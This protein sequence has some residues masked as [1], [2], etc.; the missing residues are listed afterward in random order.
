MILIKRIYQPASHPSNHKPWNANFHVKKIFVCQNCFILVKVSSCNV[1]FMRSTIHWPISFF[2]LRLKVQC[3]K[4]LK[5]IIKKLIPKKF[6]ISK[7][8]LCCHFLISDIRVD[9][10]IIFILPILFPLYELINLKFLL[11]YLSFW[12]IER[13]W[14][15]KSLKVLENIPRMSAEKRERAFGMLQTDCSFRKVRFL[16][17]S[18]LLSVIQFRC[19]DYE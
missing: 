18:M 13:I 15:E 6:L 1:A 7:I 3:G 9:H 5:T 19:F 8:I 11:L 14:H 2:F 4:G 17:C 16:K 10:K 12:F